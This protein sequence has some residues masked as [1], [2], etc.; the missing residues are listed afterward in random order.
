MVFLLCLEFLREAAN[1]FIPGTIA[2]LIP[3]STYFFGKNIIKSEKDIRTLLGVLLVL[4]VYYNI[5]ALAE[6][7]NISWLLY[8]RY[9]IEEHA[10]FKGRS[11]G[12]FLNPGIFGNA[13][14]MLL[15]IHLYFI[16]ITKQ[17]KYKALLMVSMAM[18]FAALYFTYTRGS[19]MAGL[20]CLLTAV[21]LNQKQYL[22]TLLPLVVFVPFIAI[23]F[24][25][26]GQDQ[27]M[28]ERIENDDTIGARLGTQITAL[29]VWRD[30][31]IFGCGS[32]E[33]TRVRGNYIDPIEVPFLGTIRLVNFRN[34]SA[35]DMYLGPLAEDGLFGMG[36]QFTI[37][38][39]FLISLYRKYKWRRNN[40]SFALLVI[41][42]FAGIA[43][44]YLLGGVTISYRN[45]SIMGSLFYLAAGI[46]DGL[47]AAG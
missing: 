22:K 46:T 13:I 9:M 32:F 18:G 37:Y 17:V 28:K 24:L 15:P 31:P 23:M 2:V 33:Y 39:S 20:A 47:S 30:Y 42:L 7:F 40:D 12:P 26:I 34:N 44:A 43:A 1:T 41:P 6:K 3:Y 35:H 4:C 8:P 19:W 38:G 16:A 14:G 5:T 25:G 21:A 36:L 45:I 10:E 11:N 27:F 29:R